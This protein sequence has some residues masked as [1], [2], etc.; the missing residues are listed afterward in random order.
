VPSETILTTKQ[1]EPDTRVAVE[2][3]K[4]NT[5]VVVNVAPP[6]VNPVVGQ[7]AATETKPALP[8]YQVTT[9]LKQEIYE[10]IFSKTQD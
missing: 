1:P 4:K 5:Q 7:A 3:E 9:G 8:T 2:E 6:I 10:M